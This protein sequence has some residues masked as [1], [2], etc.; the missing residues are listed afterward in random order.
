MILPKINNSS[1]NLDTQEN[2]HWREIF[3][4]FLD[5]C[6]EGVYSTVMNIR[7]MCSRMLF[8]QIKLIP[9]KQIEKYL[10]ET[11][12]SNLMN[13]ILHLLRTKV[14]TYR[15]LG[16]K[17]SSLIIHLRSEKIAAI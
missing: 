9:P 10:E 2:Q 15:Q 7:I 5:L 13:S 14:S 16:I 11:T 12:Q 6:I 1:Q 17:L 8:M 3:N 4:G